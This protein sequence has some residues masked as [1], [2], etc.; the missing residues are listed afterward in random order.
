MEDLS[1]RLRHLIEVTCQHPPGTIYRSQSLTQIIRLIQQSGKLWREA[2]R[3]YEDALQQTWVYFCRNLC[4][5][6]TGQAYDPNQA[7]VIT[8][9]N[10]Y[11]K[12]RLQDYR[13]E[14]WE[15]QAKTVAPMISASGELLDPVDNLP[16]PAPTPPILEEIRAWVQADIGAKLRRTYIRDRPEINCQTLI[17]RRLPPETPWETLATEFNISS[18]TLSSFYQRQCLPRLREFGKSQGY[19]D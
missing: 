13:V 15:Q 18:G 7:N 11:L 3:D 17:L 16:A 6:T 8:W 10:A 14:T 19:L 1:T 12:R 5:A 9:L 4:E 2:T